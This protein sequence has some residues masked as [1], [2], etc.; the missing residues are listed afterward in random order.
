MSDNYRSR[1]ERRRAMN[2]NKPEGKSQ[3]KPK[4]KKK[5]AYFVKLLPQ[6]Y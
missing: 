3:G 2:D 4:K 6:F 1:E 5:E